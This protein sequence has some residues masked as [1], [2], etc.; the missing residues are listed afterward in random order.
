LKETLK[1]NF[2]SNY[3]NFILSCLFNILLM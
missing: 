3:P 2:G 1:D